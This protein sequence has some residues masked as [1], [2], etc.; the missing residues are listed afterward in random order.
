MVRNILGS[1]FFSS[2]LCS[3]CSPIFYPVVAW[4]QTCSSLSRISF[5]SWIP[6]SFTYPWTVTN[7]PSS[8]LILI[9]LCNY[10][11][12]KI[13]PIHLQSSS[14]TL[15]LSIITSFPWQVFHLRNTHSHE[16]LDGFIN[17]FII[18][19]ILFFSSAS[20]L[21]VSGLSHMTKV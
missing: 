14:F 8:V 11:W 19:L 6:D 1:H 9:I 12:S 3:Y 10:P 18:A 15:K 20:T 13:C 17:R 5:A 7:E 2:E 4:S 16:I 21:M